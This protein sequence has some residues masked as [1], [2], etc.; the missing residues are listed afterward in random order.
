MQT[1]QKVIPQKIGHK[2]GGCGTGKTVNL[3]TNVFRQV[4][5]RNLRNL[6]K[7]EGRQGNLNKA[8]KINN[9]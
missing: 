6:I 7:T 8:G 3:V 5:H 2:Q 1:P 4:K 9:F